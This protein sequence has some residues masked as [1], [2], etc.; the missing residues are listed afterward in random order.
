MPRTQKYKYNVQKIAKNAP[1]QQN[2]N[3]VVLIII[4]V[5]CEKL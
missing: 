1:Q 2:L 3:I 4:V 5:V